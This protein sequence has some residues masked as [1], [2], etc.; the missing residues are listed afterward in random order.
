MRYFFLG[1][2]DST[3]YINQLCSKLIKGVLRK[4]NF[5]FSAVSERKKL[6]QLWNSKMHIG[7]CTYTIKYRYVEQKMNS[8]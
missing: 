7:T 8:F 5:V 4:H 6:M 1:T 2:K 3:L